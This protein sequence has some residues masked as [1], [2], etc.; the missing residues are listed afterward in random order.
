[1]RSAT[2][3]PSASCATRS[4]RRS[5]TRRQRLASGTPPN[6]GRAPF[7]DPDG[8]GDNDGRFRSFTQILWQVIGA[9]GTVLQAPSSGELPV[10]AD[11][12]RI[13][14]GTSRRSNL[15]HDVT[16][17]G[18]PYRMLTV[19]V[20]DGGAVQFARSLEETERV[21]IRIRNQTLAIVVGL[22]ALAAI[23]GIVIAQQVTRRLVR[24]TD[25]A[26]AVASSGDLD[27]QVPVEGRDE[28]GRLG[29]AFNG[30]LAS[31]A[32]SKKSQQQL[33]QDAGH[34]LRPR[35]PVCAPTC[36]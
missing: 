3:P 14:S 34:E 24:L 5:S 12:L 7:G 19:A 2:S 10:D 9:D 26:T 36:G 23:V 18:E 29:S 1:M 21:L 35:S 33:V 6:G 31:L 27:L 25:A 15:R 16:I 8:D 11:D 17:D 4:T 20:T 30:M 28:T 22:S 32:R 13:A